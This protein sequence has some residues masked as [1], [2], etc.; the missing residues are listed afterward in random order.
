[1]FQSQHFLRLM[2]A[3]VHQCNFSINGRMKTEGC[4]CPFGICPRDHA[5]V[6]VIRVAFGWGQ[7]AVVV[8]ESP[9]ENKWEVF[10]VCNVLEDG[11]CDSPALFKYLF[12]IPIWIETADP[13]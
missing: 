2:I 11:N 3:L 8:H 5:F 13:L 4:G 10:R 7:D 6:V 1:M 12:V 9:A